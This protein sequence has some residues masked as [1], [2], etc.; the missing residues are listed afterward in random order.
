ME[1]VRRGFRPDSGL[2]FAGTAGCQNNYDQKDYEDE[3]K[4]QFCEE[5]EEK[6]DKD[7]AMENEMD[8]ECEEMEELQA[9]CA[10]ESTVREE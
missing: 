8:T 7:G 6:E 3:E 1:E 4:M 9:N 10:L 5:N 2:D